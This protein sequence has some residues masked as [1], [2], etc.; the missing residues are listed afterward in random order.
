MWRTRGSKKPVR[1]KDITSTLVLLKLHWP[2]PHLLFIRAFEAGPLSPL[3]H[4]H[5]R[6]RPPSTSCSFAP[7]KPAPLPF[8]PLVHS[9]LRR[10]PPPPLTSCS[11]ASSKPAPPH[12]LFARAFEANSGSPS[13]KRS[14]SR[15]FPIPTSV[16]PPN[17]SSLVPSGAMFP[18]A[19]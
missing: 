15:A 9:H 17:A 5:L 1:P 16:P 4:S 3:L 18:L 19:L 14:S 11:F 2:L 13:P 7:S 10:R 12:L 6:S 8:P